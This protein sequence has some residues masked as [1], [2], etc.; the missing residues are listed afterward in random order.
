VINLETLSREMP[1][2]ADSALSASYV[3]ARR[4]APLEPATL[5]V[6]GLGLGLTLYPYNSIDNSS[7]NLTLAL[8]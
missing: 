2:S 6:R 3:L 1:S 8:P 5:A 4:L 7:P